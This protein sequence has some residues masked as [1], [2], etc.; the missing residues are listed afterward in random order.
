LLL[1]T[2]PVELDAVVVGIVQVESFADAV[3]GGSVERYL[4][5]DE[6]AQRVAEGG[7]RGVEHREMIEAQSCR[8][9]EGNRRGSPRC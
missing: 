1:G 3:I 6:A 9:A 7:T 4:C 8:E 2:I 5:G